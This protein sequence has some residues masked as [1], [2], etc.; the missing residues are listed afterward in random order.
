MGEENHDYFFSYL[1]I[2]LAETIQ[3]LSAV[4]LFVIA[5]E[6]FHFRKFVEF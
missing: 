2:L 4:V 3:V 6:F 1:I 5:G